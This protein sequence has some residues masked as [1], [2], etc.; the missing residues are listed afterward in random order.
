MLPKT[1]PRENYSD[2]KSLLAAL[3]KQIDGAVTYLYKHGYNYSVPR[4]FKKSKNWED[5]EDA[6][7]EGMIAFL[8]NIHNIMLYIS[9]V[10]QLHTYARNKLVD[11]FRKKVT[12]QKHFKRYFKEQDAVD[13]YQDQLDADMQEKLREA[14]TW[15]SPESQELLNLLIIENRP[16]KEVAELLGH[17]VDYVYTQKYRCIKYLRKLLR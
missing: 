16:P 7:Q 13:P 6:F 3:R 14:I 17:S 10:I 9:L 4:L 15:L 5:A 2:D 12:E 8:K 11:G 1:P